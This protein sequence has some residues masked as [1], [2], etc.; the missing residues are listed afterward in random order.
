MPFNPQFV[1][2]INCYPLTTVI[3]LAS[4]AIKICDFLWDIFFIYP[5]FSCRLKGSVKLILKYTWSF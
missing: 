4:V 1:V 5:P 3:A 2:P